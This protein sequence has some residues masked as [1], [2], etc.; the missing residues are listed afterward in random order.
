MYISD[1]NY[2]YVRTENGLIV[3]YASFKYLEDAKKTL[4]KNRK[5]YDNENM[6]VCDDATFTYFLY[7]DRLK[8]NI[9]EYI[10]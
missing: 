7:I 3:D 5:F 10:S 2:F 9:K 4:K 8:K 6:Y 1:E